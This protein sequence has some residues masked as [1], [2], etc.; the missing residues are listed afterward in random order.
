MVVRILIADD[1]P[2]VF[3]L[4]KSFL[5]RSIDDFEMISALNGR[6]AVTKA[7]DLLNTG[8]H[9]DIALIDLLMPVMDG[10][11]CTSRLI[12]LGI[13]E[14]HVLTAHVDPQLIAKAEAAGAK[15]IIKK[16][17]GYEA[18]AKRVVGLIR[19]RPLPG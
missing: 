17:E 18:I 16:S 1:E 13:N 10:I 14:I 12:E 4:L 19:S 8:S 6:E 7:Q 11:E 2:A 5:R 3:Q 15:G 9:L